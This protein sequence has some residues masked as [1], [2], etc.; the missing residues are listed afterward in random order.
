MTNLLHISEIVA[1][2]LW[3]GAILFF[4]LVVAP[5]LFRVL[6]DGAAP[7]IRNLFPKYYALGIA[8]GL[9]LVAVNAARGFLWIWNDPIT[10][11]VVVFTALT[12]VNVYA[13]QV[14]TPSIN[15]ARDA[16]EAAKARF[17]ALHRTSV[18]LNLLVMLALAGYVFWMGWRGW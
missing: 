13:R 12:L 18:M 11:S 14:L 2:S 4:S 15:A 7:V 9:V 3:F 6:G 16:G 17:A 5:S 10:G 8:C 1:I